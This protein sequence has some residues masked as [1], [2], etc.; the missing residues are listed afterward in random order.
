MPGP[1][2][3]LIT[4]EDLYDLQSLSDV[5]ISPDGRH[6]IY[7]LHR[8]DKKTEKKYGNLWIV[9]TGG[10]EPR[11]FTYG[12]QSDSSPR[13]S[14]DGRSIAFLSTRADKEKSAQIFIIPFDGGEARKLTSIEG[15]INLVGWS[16]DE[17][18]LLCTIRKTDAEVLERQKDEQKKKLG[19]V[20]RHYDRLFYKLDGYGYL[21][22]ERRHLWLV[23]ARTGKG[24]Q[25]TD[26]P[27]YDDY[28]P[29]FAPDGKSILFASNRSKDP[30]ATPDR[31]DMYVMG[32]DGSEPR[33]LKTPVGGKGFPSFSPDGKWIAYFGT[34]G[35]NEWYKSTSL[36]VTSADGTKTARNLTEQY[37]L[38][39][40]A[41]IITDFGSADTVPPVWSNDG[42]YIYF[43]A[44]YHGS[45][46]LKRINM[47]GSD[48][49]NV[50]GEGGAFGAF[51]IDKA[52]THVAY[53]YG[54]MQETPQIH[55]R[56]LGSS[57]TRYLTHINGDIFDRLK[58]PRVEEVWYKGAD[59]TDLQGW[60]MFPPNFNADK[61]YPSILEIHGGPWTQYGKFFM[62]EF[63]YLASNGYVV[64]FTNP[65]GGRG[66]GEAH[67]KAIWGAW[68][69]PDFD[70]LMVFTNF[71]AKKP[72]IDTKRMGVT[73][74][75]YGGYMTLWIVGHTDR[76]KS[77][78][79][80]RSVSNMVSMWGSS[81]FNWTFQFPAQSGSP[82][83]DMQKLWDMSPIKYLG[84]CS[85]PTLVIHSEHDHRC[86]I[87]QGEQAFV[88]LKRAGV[89]TEFVRFPNEPHG[90]SRGGRTDRRIV[91]LNHI[92]RWMDKYLK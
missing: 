69:G 43:Q 60:I 15:E 26:S 7:R 70:D 18:K 14:L 46:V 2:K 30:D 59:G 55:V 86:P 78:V 28:G 71:M 29:A 51:S 11:Q 32:L 56:E 62:H 8:V 20:A 80:Q 16:P 79:A 40:T 85:T 25:L 22:H 53:C 64:Y 54:Q 36:W 1:K 12:D 45:T 50:V 17:R 39:C 84:E 81:D 49:T 61:K 74:G 65:R 19:V 52:Q 24:K 72:Y 34:E 6:V 4:A 42:K 83:E 75:S 89:E 91:R 44:A 88:A 23:D 38:H 82:Q 21:P 90:L 73:G 63:N 76:F 67:S 10:G 47:D 33:K 48:L 13:W 77:A 58:L 35:E 9:P 87:E 41:D 68:G 31:A 3:R 92:L 27:I 5:R 37:D 57:T 66:Y